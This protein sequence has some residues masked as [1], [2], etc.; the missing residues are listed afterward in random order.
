MDGDYSLAEF[1]AVIEEIRIES[2]Q[3]LL[4]TNLPANLYPA[5]GQYMLAALQGGAELL[6]VL[7]YPAIGKE[8]DFLLGTEYSASWQPGRKV[9]LR[10]PQG[11]G[12][13]LPRSTR[14]VGLAAIDGSLLRLLPL[15]HQALDQNAAV[16]CCSAGVPA[17]LPPD[18]EVVPPENLADLWAWA[19]YAAILV[20]MHS[21]DGLR[22]RLGLA[23]QSPAALSV[24]ILV[25]F[26]M[27]CGGISECGVCAVPL[28]RGWA[29]ACKDGP[30]FNLNQLEG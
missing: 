8:G 27:V 3:L 19:D 17:Y 20:G 30:V 25:D 1:H 10:G 2:G 15:V 13:V 22:D 29:L 21:L 11:Q 23:G 7:L 24:E 9:R 28:R 5:A 4:K 26:P 16:V 18:V 14:R 12:F 6:P